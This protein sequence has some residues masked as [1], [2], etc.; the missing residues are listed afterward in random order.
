MSFSAQPLFRLRVAEKT[1]EAEGVV[2]FRLLGERGQPLPG[3][4]AGA[5]IDVQML[6]DLVRQY[7]LCNPSMAP[8]AYEIAVLR[9]PASRGGS[10][11]MHETL[12]VGMEVLVGA[13]RNHFQLDE[14]APAL[15]FAGGIGIT[16]LLAMAQQLDGEGR[17]FEL[18]YCVRNRDRAAFRARLAESTYADRVHFHY[19]DEA[20]SQRLDAAA[21][22]SRASSAHHLYVCGPAGFIQYVLDT[23]REAGWPEERVHREFF[24]APVLDAEV[25]DGPFELELARSDKRF[26]VPADRTVLA[27]LVDAGIEVSTSCEAGVCGTCVTRVIDGTPD[28]RDV[29]LTDAEHA[30][31][32][33]FTPC[34]SRALSKRLV[35]DL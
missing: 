4:T 34:C 28:H 29:Y 17:E 26:T 7:S 5:H 10:R 20:D 31:N 1:A 27:V 3:F 9:E 30:R 35:I 13:P 22:L 33:C 6:P 18:H 16:P 8:A 15:L 2:A 25:A 11:F 24:T 14:R 21:V 19:D 32:D 23:A 12:A